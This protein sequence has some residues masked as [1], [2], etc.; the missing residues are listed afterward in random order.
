MDATALDLPEQSM[1]L[2]F[3]SKFAHELSPQDIRAVMT[4][5]HRLLRPGGLM[6]H[7]ELPPNDS[8]VH[9]ATAVTGEQLAFSDKTGRLTDGVQ[10]YGFGAWK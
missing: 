9:Y 2:L 3:S 6:L 1:D 10:W 7:M 8:L 5:A 4:E